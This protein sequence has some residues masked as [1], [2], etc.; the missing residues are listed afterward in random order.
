[1]PLPESLLENLAAM[2]SLLAGAFRLVPEEHHRWTPASWDGIP[3]ERFSPLGQLCHVRDI[4]V[5]GY[6]VRIARMLGE[7]EPSLVSLDGYALAEAGGYDSSDPA[8]VLRQFSEARSSTLALLR[9]LTPAQLL[10]S[11]TFAEYGSLTLRSLVHYLSSH[12]CQ[13]LA[14]MDWLLG[15][16]HSFRSN[17]A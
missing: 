9:A 13:H 3:G 7:D 2:P 12:D 16:L 14:C 10:R 8:A 1:M 4:E 5:L 15:K 11:G 6:H 17:E